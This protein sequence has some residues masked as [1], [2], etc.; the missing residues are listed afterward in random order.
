MDLG[1]GRI[2][3]LAWFLYMGLPCV[4]GLL[5]LSG[6]GKR[7]CCFKDPTIVDEIAN[8]QNPNHGLK[9]LPEVVWLSPG[10]FAVQIVINEGSQSFLTHINSV[11]RH[12]K[13]FGSLTQ[14]EKIAHVRLTLQITTQLLTEV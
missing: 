9:S 2:P 11:P 14:V 12:S 5:H 4:V 13:N 7:S 8:P 6:E 3:G 10:S 1:D